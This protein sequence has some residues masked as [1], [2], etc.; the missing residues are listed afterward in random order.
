MRRR[1]WILGSALGVGALA[2]AGSGEALSRP[3]LCDVGPPPA[4]LPVE[5]VSMR[6]SSNG[7]VA[8]WF[9][10][11][12]AGRGAVLLLHGVRSNR[13]A[14]VTRARFLLRLGFATLLIDLPAHGESPAPHMTYGANE[15]LGVRAALAFLAARLPG[16]RI[17]AVGVSLGAA[18]LV[19]A[20]P[21]PAPSAVVLESMFPT[22]EEAV[23]DRLA[24]HL[25]A[26]A[27][28][29]APLLLWQVPLRLGISTAQLHPIDALPQLK[30]PVFILAG[31]ADRHTTLAESRRLYAAAN[32]PKTLWILD[33]AAHVDLHAF[34]PAAYE[35][36]VGAFL[37]RH[38]A[39]DRIDAATVAA[40][41][42]GRR[43]A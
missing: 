4:D 30:T 14:M 26:F 22:I 15:A 1:T 9:V 36:R 17:G 41:D 38:L 43:H 19:L 33:G 39:G 31:S 6:T 7:T 3:A 21:D 27:A 42:D 12:Q 32:D 23:A 28:P 35:A 20:R 10:P 18:S 2:V 37:A 5:R 25:G 11:G 16:E 8:G 34:A 13:L 24:L 40:L 29:L